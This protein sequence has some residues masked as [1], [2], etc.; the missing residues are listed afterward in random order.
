MVACVS[1][2][3]VHCSKISVNYMEEMYDLGGRDIDEMMGLKLM[4]E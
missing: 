1:S 4:S 3:R 2:G